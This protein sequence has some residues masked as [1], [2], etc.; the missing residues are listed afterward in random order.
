MRPLLKSRK[1]ET[2][3][4]AVEACGY[5]LKRRRDLFK[6]SPLADRMLGKIRAK[7]RAEN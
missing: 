6:L 3:D 7:A 2:P 4:L 1:T 5:S